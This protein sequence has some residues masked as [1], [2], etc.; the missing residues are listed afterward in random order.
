M[1][2]KRSLRFATHL[3]EL[4][5]LSEA[6]EELGEAEDWPFDL[7]FQI[8]LVLE[9]LVV[10]IVNHGHDGDPDHEIEIAFTSEA[11]ALTIELIDHGR[12]FNPLDDAP[13]PDLDSEVEDRPIGGLGIHLVRTAID[14]M[15]YKRENGKNH[16][17]LIKRREG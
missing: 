5:R 7:V 8:N 11:D 17:T 10:N 1:S 15:I 4:A 2:A 12:A 13:E 14:A 3:D 6:I 16:L 9:E